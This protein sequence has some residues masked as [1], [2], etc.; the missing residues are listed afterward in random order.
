MRLQPYGQAVP[1][2]TTAELVVRRRVKRAASTASPKLITAGSSPRG[3]LPSR[4][5]EKGNH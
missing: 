1:M 2:V 3:R 5:V 4:V